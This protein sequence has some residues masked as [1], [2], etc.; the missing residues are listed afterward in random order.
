MPSSPVVAFG[1]EVPGWGSW[2]WCGRDIQAELS[3]YFSTVSFLTNPVSD[4]QVVFIIKHV[5]SHE[6]VELAAR[7]ARVVYCPVDYYGSA[8]EI[9]ADARML[10]KCSQILVHCQALR[11]YFEPYA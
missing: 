10:G 4:C 1:P 11:K 2:D 6:L 8:A 5:L 3:K 9:D 7:C